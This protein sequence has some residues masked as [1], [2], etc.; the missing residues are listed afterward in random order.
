MIKKVPVPRHRGEKHLPTFKKS[1]ISGVEKYLKLG[2]NLTKSCEF[3]FIPRQTFVQ[4]CNDPKLRQKVQYWRNYVSIKARET[5]SKAVTEHS[6]LEDSKWWAERKDRKD[7][8]TRVEQVEMDD[9]DMQEDKDFSDID[10]I[11]K[12]NTK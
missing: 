10:E 4:W 1:V 6:S 7:F 2:Y 5:I 9:D 3:A 12:K 8:S 11:I